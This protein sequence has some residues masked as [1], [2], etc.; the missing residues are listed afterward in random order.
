MTT[1]VFSVLFHHP[2]AGKG[3]SLGEKNSQ[4][5]TVHKEVK[6]IFPEKF[7]FLSYYNPK[8]DPFQFSYACV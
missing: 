1:A 7:L 3:P 6:S 4:G 2:V 8:P 5:I